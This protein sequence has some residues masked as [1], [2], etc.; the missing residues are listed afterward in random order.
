VAEPIYLT[1]VRYPADGS[2]VRVH[3]LEL[4]AGERLVI[5]GPNGSGKTSLLRLLAGTLPGGPALDAAYLPQRPYLFRGSALRNLTL[6]LSD[7]ETDRASRLAVD[8]G[9]APRLDADVRTLSGGERQRVA[10]AAVLARDAPTVLLD[11]PLA[12]LDL[13]DRDHM[14]EAIAGALVG[15]TAVIVSHDRESVATLGDRVAVMVDG[16]VRQIGDVGEVFTTP[17][18]DE[19]AAVVGVANVLSGVVASGD[20]SL[21]DVTCG[22]VVIR[23]LGDQDPGVAVKVLFGAETVGVFRGE[24]PVGSPRNTW[25]GP[26]IAIRAVGRLHEI[27]VDCGVPIA[28]LVT[29]GALDAIGVGVGDP[30][31]LSA[32]ATAV[33]AVTTGGP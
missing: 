27:V 18:D 5:F 23:G 2:V 29:P 21:V 20:G 12:P 11:E 6:G 16:A 8:L 25:G 19:V 31:H 22:P 28:A 14:A 13:R 32:K 9:V 30:V 17:A 33:R 15:K 3:D 7:T 24:P 4:H 26:V 10:L 1:D